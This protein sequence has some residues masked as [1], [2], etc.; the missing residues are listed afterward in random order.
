MRVRAT[1]VAI[2][3]VGN[4]LQGDDGVGVRAVQVLQGKDGLGD[5]EIIDAG[6]AP[7]DMLGVFLESR[8][9]I[10]LDCVRTGREP[11]TL[12]RL[13]PEAIDGA[14]DDLR[15]AHGLG[16][17]GTVRLARELGSTADVIVYGIEPACIEWGLELSSQVE[18]SL[19]VLVDAVREEVA[20]ASV[21]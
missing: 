18:T 15:F 17:A 14:D 2:I 13:P 11:G 12:Y 20:R 4:I 16:V 19:P 21:A 3:G 6:T 1:D 8:L 5:V 7:F 10:V 9:V